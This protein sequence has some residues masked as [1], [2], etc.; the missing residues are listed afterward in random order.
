M[1]RFQSIQEVLRFAMA[2]EDTSRRF[3]L[4]LSR[5]VSNPGAQ[6]IFEALAAAEARQ[7][8]A[9]RLELFKIGSTVPPLEQAPESAEARSSPLDPQ[10]RQMS[11][12]DALQLAMRK[13]KDSF[14]MFAELMVHTD[15]PEAAEILYN[16][17]EVEMRHLLKLEKEYNALTPHRRNP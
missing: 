13:Q 12:P 5:S 6:A 15:N 17:A 14:R 4:D 3:Y 1:M 8:E 11:A 2:R 9:I 10:I 16:L 7:L